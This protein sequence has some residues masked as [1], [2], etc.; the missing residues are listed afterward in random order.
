MFVVAMTPV[1]HDIEPKIS[2]VL[3]NNNSFCLDSMEDFK[4]EWD[5]LKF[6]RDITRGVIIA[7]GAEKDMMSL[8]EAMCSDQDWQVGVWLV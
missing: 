1:A 8:F 7:Y 5:R 6:S 4:G 3:D 2:S